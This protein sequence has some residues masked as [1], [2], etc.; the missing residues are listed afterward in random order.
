MTWTG[1][2]VVADVLVTPS[3]AVVVMSEAFG[4]GP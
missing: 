4:V 1:V 3:S 2:P